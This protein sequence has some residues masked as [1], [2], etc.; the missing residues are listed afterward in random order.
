MNTKLTRQKGLIGCVVACISMLTLAGCQPKS[1]T[2]TQDLITERQE[3]YLKDTPYPTGGERAQTVAIDIPVS[4]PQTLVDS[5]LALI[6]EELYAYFDNYT[7]YVPTDSLLHGDVRKLIERYRDRYSP[8]FTDTLTAYDFTTDC[9]ELNL[10]AQTNS[11]VTYAVNCIHYG[12]G[13]E[14]STD[15]ETF[16]KSDGHRVKEIISEQ[17][18]ARFYAEHPEL[19]D[20]NVWANELRFHRE[21]GRWNIVCSVGLLN[22]S[23]AHQYGYAAGIFEDLKYPFDVISPYL[24]G[25]AQELIKGKDSSK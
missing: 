12:E 19:R 24:S 3:C 23:L 15:W 9:L 20:E 18:M 10:V 6:N 14:V 11:Y 13:I 7:Y 5:V 4:G 22:D 21:N 17:E 1:G 16:A 2:D 8:F 25:E